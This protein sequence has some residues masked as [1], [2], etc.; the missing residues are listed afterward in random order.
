VSA[1]AAQRR[2]TERDRRHLRR[3]VE[4]SRI[5]APGAGDR[6]FGAVVGLGDDVLGEAHNE[7]ASRCDPTAH[8]EILA[9]RAAGGRLHS[10]ALDGAVLYS[11]S[12][13]CPMCLTACYWA[14][15]A[16]VVYA[17]TVGDTDDFGFNDAVYYRELARPAHRRALHA[18]PADGELRTE[19]LTVLRR[20]R[21]R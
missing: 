5:P 8:A 18:E 20:W 10:P 1:R 12:E 15:I 6:P 21:G 4:L 2:E 9:L 14:R 3:A 11:S 17:A 7:V 16:R 19:A 13:P